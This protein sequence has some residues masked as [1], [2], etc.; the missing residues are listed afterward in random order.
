MKNLLI[1]ISIVFLSSDSIKNEKKIPEIEVQAEHIY[2]KIDS[3]SNRVDSLILILLD[4][5]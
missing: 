4:T 5:I 2:S 1:I 3:L